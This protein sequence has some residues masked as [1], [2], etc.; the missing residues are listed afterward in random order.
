MEAVFL[1]FIKRFKVYL[2]NAKHWLWAVGHTFSFLLK[3]GA[4]YLTCLVPRLQI[5]CDIVFPHWLVIWCLSW[6][7]M[8][9]EIKWRLHYWLLPDLTVNMLVT[10]FFALIFCSEIFRHYSALHSWPARFSAVSHSYGYGLLDAK[11]MVTLAKNWTT[12]GPQH[13]CVHPMLT[14]ARLVNFRHFYCSVW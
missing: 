4:T 7:R 3:Y 2:H 9:K 8:S 13:Q 5:N 14:E 1:W 6:G 12:V 10:W 11:A